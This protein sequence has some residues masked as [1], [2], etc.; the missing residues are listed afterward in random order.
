MEEKIYAR[1]LTKKEYAKWWRES[2]PDRTLEWKVL[3]YHKIWNKHNPD[4]PIVRGDGYVIHHKD[5]NP[6]N[7]NIDNLQKMTRGAHHSLHNS[8]ENHP[9]Y[10]KRHT[11]K[12]R[13][14]ISE[15][16][17]GRTLSE[18]HKK[19][20]SEAKKGEKHP[21]YGRKHTKE[22]RKKMSESQN[23]RWAVRSRS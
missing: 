22:S 23:K 15:A 16:I 9:M 6:K 13:K 21:M 18:I 19:K 5:E 14:K 10:G 11:K 4:D 1:G 17:S 7:N 8:G 20:L 12:V 3:K 2:N